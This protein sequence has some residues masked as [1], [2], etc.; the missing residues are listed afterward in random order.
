MVFSTYPTMIGAISGQE[1]VNQRPFTVGHFDLII[2]DESHRSIYQKYKSIFDYF[3]ARIVGLT[4]TPR[5]DLDKNTYGFF[6][7]GEWGSNIC[8]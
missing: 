1:E 4:A 5:Q 6:N 3:D 8:I 2:I 7:L